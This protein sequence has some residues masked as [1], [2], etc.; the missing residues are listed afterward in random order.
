MLKNYKKKTEGFTIIEVLIV[1]AIAGLIMLI[2]FLAVP[3]LQRNTRNT[4][5][6]NDA[7]RLSTA[8][9]DYVSNDGDVL[10]ATATWATACTSILNDAGAL[11]Q[12]AWAAANCTTTQG[13]NSFVLVTG[14][15]TAT[16]QTTGDEA[17]LSTAAICNGTNATTATG[18]T[19]RNAALLYDLETG[20]G[21]YNWSCLNIE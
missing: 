20:G 10:P 14:A 8:V 1:L 13:A 15:A 21:N 17:I 9:N 7:G 19:S 5:R 2:V 12:G 4:G 18:A 16:A 6:K 3:A 11:N